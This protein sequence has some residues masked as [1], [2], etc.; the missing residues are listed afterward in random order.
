MSYKLYVPVEFSQGQHVVVIFTFKTPE[1]EKNIYPFFYFYR[2]MKYIVFI[3][4][5]IYVLFPHKGYSQPDNSFPENGLWTIATWSFGIVVSN[6]QYA[7][8][9]DTVINSINYKK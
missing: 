7:T 5:V 8:E 2:F 3:Y 1:I 4:I 9:G 6:R